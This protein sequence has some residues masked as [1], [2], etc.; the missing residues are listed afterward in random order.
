MSLRI[1][2]ATLR[3]TLATLFCATVW[4]APASAD[5]GSGEK[6]STQK[7]KLP[8]EIVSVPMDNWGGRPVVQARINGQ[9]P[10]KLLIDT[11]TTSAAILSDSLIK[12]VGISVAGPAPSLGAIGE[13]DHVTVEAITIGEAEFS[14]VRARRADF[15]GFMPPGPSAPEGI[16]GL[17]LVNDCLFTLD[18]P[19]SKIL[20]ESGEM[21]EHQCGNVG[22]RLLKD[23]AVTLDQKNR[24]LRLHRPSTDNG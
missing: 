14:N 22:Y 23:F 10:F 21:V 19:N 16:L 24:L 7:T 5:T 6:G 15:S 2:L 4:W 11:G 12:K 9:G 13:D 3:I 8:K 20:L 18:Y 17:P 1:T